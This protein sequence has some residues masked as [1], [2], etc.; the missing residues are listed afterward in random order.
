MCRHNDF[1]LHFSKD[2]HQVGTTDS[3][4]NKGILF[5]LFSNQK[6]QQNCTCCKQCCIHL[7]SEQKSLKVIVFQSRLEFGSTNTKLIQLLILFI[8]C[9]VSQKIKIILEILLQI[10]CQNDALPLWCVLNAYHP[11]SPLDS[12]SSVC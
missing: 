6:L 1:L 5:C 12:L 10:R 11:I 3:A 8:A 4:S 9:I 7:K 2:K